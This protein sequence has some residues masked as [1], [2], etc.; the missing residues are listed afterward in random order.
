VISNECTGWN[1]QVNW[2]GR[3]TRTIHGSKGGFSALKRVARGPDIVG[4]RLHVGLFANEIGFRIPEQ[5]ER[6]PT[7]VS[8]RKSE[9]CR[10]AIGVLKLIAAD[11]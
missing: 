4:T 7:K 8:T 2:G 10:C 1:R 6:D 9:D 3:G 5:K 11:K